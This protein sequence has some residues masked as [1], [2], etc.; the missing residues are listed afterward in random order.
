MTKWYL[1]D[2]KL[3]YPSQLMTF[4]ISKCCKLFYNSQA[5]SEQR[6]L[7][8]LKRQSVCMASN[9][10]SPQTYGE[11]IFRDDEQ[12]VGTVVHINGVSASQFSINLF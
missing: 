11:L 9:V 7:M 4:H 2:M 10:R 12:K 8:P 6:Y 1:Y 3:I 5:L